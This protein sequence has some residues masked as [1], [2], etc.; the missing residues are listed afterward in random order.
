M[1]KNGDLVTVREG[2]VRDNQTGVH[3][4]I[5]DP[6]RHPSHPT[7]TYIVAAPVLNDAT[8]GLPKLYRVGDLRTAAEARFCSIHG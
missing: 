4:V 7:R 2:I 5:A 3:Q 1:M 8:L 6:I